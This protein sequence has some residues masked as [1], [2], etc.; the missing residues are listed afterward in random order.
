MEAIKPSER[1]NEKAMRDFLNAQSQGCSVGVEDKPRWSAV[2]V[3]AEARSRTKALNTDNA[4]QVS[5][6]LAGLM[7]EAG[8]DEDEFIQVLCKDVIQRGTH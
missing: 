4:R 6:M 5:K 7:E 1:K 8:W 2:R 3:L